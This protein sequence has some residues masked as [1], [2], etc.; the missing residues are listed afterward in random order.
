MKIE[1]E[2]MIDKFRDENSVLRQEKEF[3]Q[4]K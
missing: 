2:E 4:V 1:F 3:F